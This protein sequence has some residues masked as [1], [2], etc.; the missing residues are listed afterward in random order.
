MT[1][2]DYA[3]SSDDEPDDIDDIGDEPPAEAQASRPSAMLGITAA[4]LALVCGAIGI[5]GVAVASSGDYA[6]GT[7]L[8]Q[9]AIGGTLVAFV[10]GV[11]AIILRRGRGWGVAALAVSFIANPL[12][13]I[14][15]FDFFGRFT[16]A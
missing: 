4:A 2:N 7:V 1:T 5:V 15:I 8:A 16:G 11:L 12:A 6:F 10:L 13:Q 14:Q 9:L 3:A